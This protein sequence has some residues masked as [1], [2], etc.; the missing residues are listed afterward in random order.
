MPFDPAE[1]REYMEKVRLMYDLAR[2]AFETDSTRPVTLMLDSVNTPAI[3]IEGDQDHRRLP[4]PL[5]PRQIREK[6][7]QLKAID[8]WHMKLLADLFT[9]AQ[10]GEG[11]GRDAARP[12][13]GP[14]RLATSA[15]PTPT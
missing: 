11:R 5:A 13:D 8:E 9:R 2:L 6:L 1:P 4:Q 7:T 10:G 3:E 14:L 15:T 12:H